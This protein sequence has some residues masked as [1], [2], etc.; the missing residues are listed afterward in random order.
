MTRYEHKLLKHIHAHPH[1]SN[2]E[3]GKAFLNSKALEYS[4]T[5]L[6]DDDNIECIKAYPEDDDIIVIGGV[7]TQDNWTTTPKGEYTLENCKLDLRASIR[8]YLLGLL[9][10]IFIST[11]AA[12]IVNAVHI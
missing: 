7:D 9:S 11:A 5:V 12:L 3:L 6:W 8:S 2:N 1:I 4:L 10:G